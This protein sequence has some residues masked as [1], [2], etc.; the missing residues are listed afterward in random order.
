MNP[1]A[2]NQK[3]Q[4]MIAFCTCYYLWCIVSSLQLDVRSTKGRNSVLLTTLS[5]AK[6]NVDYGRGCRVSCIIREINYYREQFLKEAVSMMCVS[7]TRVEN[8]SCQPTENIIHSDYW[9]GISWTG[10]S[11]HH[12]ALSCHHPL[13]LKT[14]TFWSRIVL[15]HMLG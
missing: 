12:G 4:T 6:G 13:L 1:S 3:I 11:L 14:T 9:D 10:T 8:G 2:S 5:N 15:E 7:E